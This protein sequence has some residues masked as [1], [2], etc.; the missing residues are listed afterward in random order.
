MIVIRPKDIGNAVVRLGINTIQATK[1][2]F[3]ST[4]IILE[5]PFEFMAEL[6]SKDFLLSPLNSD[7]CRI[8]IQTDQTKIPLD[9]I[10]TKIL[11]DSFSHSDGLFADLQHFDTK[12]AQPEIFLF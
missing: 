11:L 5:P 10:V 9:Q 1:D 4:Q 2:D 8:Q 3:S 7:R 12:M 6:V